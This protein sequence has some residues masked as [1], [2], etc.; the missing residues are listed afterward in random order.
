MVLGQF[1]LQDQPINKET[2]DALKTVRSIPVERAS[3]P[4]AKLYFITP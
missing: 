1:T 2:H 3:A 4:T